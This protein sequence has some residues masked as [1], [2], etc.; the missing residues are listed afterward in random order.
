MDITQLVTNTHPEVINWR[1]ELHKKPELSYNEFNTANYVADLLT[2]FGDYEVLRPT[3]NSVVARLIADKPGKVLALRADMDAL[4]LTE[5]NECEYKSQHNGV[6]HAC[7]HDGHTASL[8]GVAKILSQHK[9]ELT[10]EVRLIFQHAEETPPGGAKELV[11]LGVLENVDMIIGIHLWSTMPIGKVGVIGGAMMAAPD[12]FNLEIKGKG[13]HGGFPHQAIDTITIGAQVVTNLQQI[14]ARQINPLEPVVIS[15]TKFI[16]GTTHN[17]LPHTAE[18]AGTVRT[19]DNKV[20]HTIPELMER[21]IRGITSAHGADYAF[22]YTY[23]YDPV[24]NNHQVATFVE[25]V[26]VDTLGG[27]WVDKM[28]SNMAG[29]DFSA[30]LAKVPGCFIFVGAGNEAKGIIHPHHH[31]RFNIDEDALAVSMKIFL[32]AVTKYLGENKCA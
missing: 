13:G 10:G 14:V 8:L 18:I 25:E 5:L 11:D 6:M 26:V 2:Q 29:E 4:P 7:G 21:I 9:D 20:R 32:G 1:R 27:Q 15:V 22:N 3:P 17:I 19:F 31:P 24:V 28:A 23:G 16:S 12:V 30:Y